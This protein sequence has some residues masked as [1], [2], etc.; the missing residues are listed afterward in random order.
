MMSNMVPSESEY[1]VEAMIMDGYFLEGTTQN[2]SW[3]LPVENL[4][5]TTVHLLIPSGP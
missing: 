2:Y 1:V 4:E 3:M 5:V